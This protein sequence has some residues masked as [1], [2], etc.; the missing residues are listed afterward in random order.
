MAQTR[1]SW[2]PGQSGNP[3]GRPRL[4]NSIT[5]L[6]RQN[7]DKQRFVEALLNLAYSG[8]LPAIR[9][10]MQYHDGLPAAMEPGEGQVAQPNVVLFLPD[11]GRHVRLPGEL[12]VDDEGMR[13][14]VD[15]VYGNGRT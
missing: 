8:D 1:T 15:A 6:I 7:L 4:G 2:K 13:S 5:E 3:S 12:G 9:L 11:N 14:E 10:V